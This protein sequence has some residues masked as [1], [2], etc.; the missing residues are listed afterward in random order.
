MKNYFGVSNFFL[1]VKAVT[2]TIEHFLEDLN[3][4]GQIIKPY[5]SSPL[6]DNAGHSIKSVDCTFCFTLR[7]G[8]VSSMSPWIVYKFVFSQFKMTATVVVQSIAPE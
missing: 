4:T 7:V 1:V 5:T 3:S 8:I 2:W 6:R